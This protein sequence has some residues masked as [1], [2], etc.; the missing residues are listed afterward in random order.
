VT[1]EDAEPRRTA[2]AELIAANPDVIVAA[3]MIDALAVHAL[4][5]T[6]PMVVIR[7]NDL[8]EVGLADSLARPGGNVTEPEWRSRSE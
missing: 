7:G 1:G 4:T 8:V 2:A 5:R 3:G 6:I